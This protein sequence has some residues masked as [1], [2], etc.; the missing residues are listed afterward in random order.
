M[1]VL[2]GASVKLASSLFP[3]F[4]D[5]KISAYTKIISRLECKLQKGK[6]SIWQLGAL[7]LIGLKVEGKGPK[8]FAGD[9]LVID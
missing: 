8:I 9:E 4:A 6:K 1:A 5:E 3:V 7:I 2:H